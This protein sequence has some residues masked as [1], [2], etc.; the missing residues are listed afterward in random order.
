M[1]VPR[2]LS[3]KLKHEVTH[4]TDMEIVLLRELGIKRLIPLFDLVEFAREEF[5]TFTA[6]FE[7]LM[8]NLLKI[9]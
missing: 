9:L 1:E 2:E 6:Q 5:V 8:Q 7:M 3:L 4:D